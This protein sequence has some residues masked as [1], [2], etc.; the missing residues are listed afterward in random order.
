[1]LDSRFRNQAPPSIR[2]MIRQ[3][4]R[5]ISG[6]L[7]DGGLLPLHYRPLY[8]TRIVAWA[9]SPLVPILVLAAALFPTTAP[10]MEWYRPISLML[11]GMLF[12]Y[13]AVGL[14]GYRKHP[15]L[16]P[17]FIVATPIAFVTHSI[18]ALWGIVRPVE[19]FEVTEK[20]TPDVIEERH[21]EL[22]AGDLT[23][24]DGTER[25]VRENEG[26]FV[27]NVFDD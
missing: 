20:V 7:A 25:L 21:N 24:H 5:W 19:T 3:R 17:L 13:M 26:A 4:R 10:T 12:V 9:F 23:D 1:M 11:F 22:A 15:L 8:L 27:T 18:G 6:T 2:A 16:W 14:L